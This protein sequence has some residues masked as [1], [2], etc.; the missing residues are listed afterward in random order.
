M[1]PDAERFRLLAGPYRMPKCKIGGWLTCRIRGR[2]RVVAI[3]DGLI[4]WPMAQQKN[5]GNKTLIVC[6]DLAKAIGRESA[7]AVA[8]WW[9]V[10]PQTVSLWRKALGVE[11]NNKGTRKLRSKWWN[12]GG[13]EE[14]SRPGR[15]ATFDSPERAAKI[16]AAR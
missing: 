10:S 15:E 11:Q 3:S 9:G 16:A 13:V 6:G 12:E 5:G 1:L 14:A 2:V 4:Q 8:H 7:Q